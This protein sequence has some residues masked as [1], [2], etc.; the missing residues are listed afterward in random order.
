MIAGY[1]AALGR[2]YVRCRLH[3]PRLG[4]IQDVDFLVDTGTNAS[5]LHPRD[6]TRIGCPFDEL[7]YPV[8]MTSAAG[9]HTYYAESAIISFYDGEARHDFRIKLHIGKPHPVTNVLDSLLGLDILNELEMEYAPLRGQ[10]R[11]Y[12]DAER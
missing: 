11:F 4:I 12:L 1:F 7:S 5:I 9:P 6:G 2:P 3:L 10:L 8:P